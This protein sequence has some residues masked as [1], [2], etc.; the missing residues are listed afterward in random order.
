MR[1]VTAIIL[2]LV[3]IA[4]V[5]VPD[6]AAQMP[7]TMNYQGMLTSGSTPVP[8][9]NYNVTFRLY[10]ASTGGSA[11]WAEAQLVTTR[12]GVFNA[13]LGKIVALPASFS[14]SYWMS[15]QIGTDA[16]LTPRLEMTGV[17]YSMHSLVADSAKK[18]ADGS[19]NS[20]AL[21]TGSV[22]TAK[23]PD[24]AIGYR[25]VASNSLL[26]SNILDEP[27]VSSSTDAS[28]GMDAGDASYTL[29]SVDITL[30]ASGVVV[31]MGTGYVN[32]W[33]TTGT[34][35]SVWVGVNTVPGSMSSSSASSVY[36]HLSADHPTD[37]HTVP[38]TSVSVVSETSAG[39]KRYYLNARHSSGASTLT[40]IAHVVLTAMYFPTLRGT[41]N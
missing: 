11:V 19:I 8:D 31:I 6:A 13:I 28:I 29:D 4:P 36:A 33:H 17:S 30:P 32:L 41:I 24:G 25:Q 38:F 14:T 20:A 15:L 7:R 5:S 35:T 26:A 27:G 1:I 39:A 16:E 22:T 9:G 12:N 40:N 34:A 2:A 18:V 37:L 21:A 23:I 10:T 3:V